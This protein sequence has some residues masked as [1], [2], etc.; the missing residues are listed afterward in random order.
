[1]IGSGYHFGSSYEENSTNASSNSTE[2]CYSLETTSTGALHY[3]ATVLTVI[4]FFSIFGNVLVLVLFA[5]F[6]ELRTRSVVVSM[7]MVV[8]DLLFTLA[9]TLQAIVTTVNARW[10]FGEVGCGVFGFLASDLLTTRWLIVSMLCMDRFLHVRFPFTYAITTR[11]KCL[12]ITLTTLAWILPVVASVIPLAAQ[13]EMFDL[14]ENQPVCLPVCTGEFA[15]VCRTYY[16][17]IFTTVFILGSIVPV[18]LYSWLGYKARK[19]KKST[20]LTL[21]R[22]TIDIAG[23]IAASQQVSEQNSRTKRE[24]QAT[25]TFILLIAT[26]VVT[27]TPGYALQVIRAVAFEESCR[28]HILVHFIVIEFLLCAPMLTPL[29]VMRDAAFRNSLIKLFRCRKKT[30]DLQLNRSPSESKSFINNRRA[31]VVSS[32]QTSQESSSNDGSPI[33]DRRFRRNSISMKPAVYTISESCESLPR[34]PSTSQV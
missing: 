12:Q 30:G 9:Y 6:K 23:G 22:L 5:R 26:V 19:L 34:V 29:V 17:L 18:V 24:N 1:M 2:D 13:I 10:V 25:V 4:G 33:P 11:G 32:A 28:I 20:N 21:G 31:S 15:G 3:H 7:S 14:R 8:A 16:F 27:G